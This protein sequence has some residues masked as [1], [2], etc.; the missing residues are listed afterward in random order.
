MKILN[1]EL[2]PMNTAYSKGQNDFVTFDESVY[3]NL[4][5]RAILIKEHDKSWF[6]FKKGTASP[7]IEVPVFD[8]RMGDIFEIT[9][10]GKK[11]TSLDTQV[12]LDVNEINLNGSTIKTTTYP[13]LLNEENVFSDYKIRGVVPNSFL[14]TSVGVCLN[15]RVNSGEAIIK[16]LKLKIETTNL[17]LSV[18][19]E[20]IAM[21]KKQHFDFASNNNLRL[22]YLTDNYTQIIPFLDSARTLNDDGSIKFT[23]GNYYRGLVS[24]ISDTKN[25]AVSI[26]LEYKS[27]SDFTAGIRYTAN[28][29]RQSGKGTF[30]NSN[31]EWTKAIV[32][33]FIS[34]DNWGDEVIEISGI[35]SS[36]EMTIKKCIIC[37]D[38]ISNRFNSEI[39]DKLFVLN[40]SNT[41]DTKNKGLYN[42]SRTIG[43]LVKKISNTDFVIQ[44]KTDDNY[45]LSFD[46]SISN[47]LKAT[48]VPQLDFNKCITIA[49][50]TGD[51]GGKYTA[52]ASESFDKYVKINFFDNTNNRVDISSI[53]NNSYF[54]ISTTFMSFGDV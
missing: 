21:Y 3:N 32:R 54:Y 8:V 46:T 39:N 47:Q 10:S 11:I 33:G 18:N 36:S 25:R 17:N 13:I 27:T 4:S 9:F 15:V 37:N 2:S 38:C 29:S 19:E 44:T 53:P 23:G 30:R 49:Q 51:T 41:I 50:M 12:S 45:D 6:K 16:N 28:G 31:N 48:Y 40:S 52:R 5:A 14:N 22:K 34:H 7:Y 26:Y 35:T 20:C 24:K 1:I 42:T 43:F